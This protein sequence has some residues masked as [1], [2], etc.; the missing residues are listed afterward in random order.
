VSPWQIS[1]PSIKPLPRY[2]DFSLFQD[3]GGRHLG[4]L[5]IGNMNSCNSQESQTASSYQISWR[6][7]APLVRYCDFSIYPRWRLSTILDLWCAFLD[8][9]QRSFGG[10]CHCAKFGLN[11]Y[12]SFDSTHV[13]IFCNLKMPIHHQKLGFWGFWPPKWGP[14]W[15]RLPKCISL[16]GNTWN[17]DRQNRSTGACCARD[18]EWSKKKNRYTKKPQHVKSRVRRDYPRCRSTTWILRVWSQPRHSYI[19]QVSLWSPY[20]IGQT[21]IFLPCDFFLSSPFFFFFFFF[22]A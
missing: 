18:Q 9:P 3:G 22:L 11:R 21:I 17:I 14:V 8:H 2:C 19:F 20:V 6:L 10:L 16:R 12:S 4:F 7:V 1:W 5:N 15:S 13:L